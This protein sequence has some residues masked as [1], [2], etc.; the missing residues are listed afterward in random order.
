MI[1]AIHPIQQVSA[2]YIGNKTNNETLRLS[3]LPLDVTDEKLQELLRTYFLSNFTAPEFHNFTFSNE[4]FTLNPLFQFVKE[5][6]SAPETFHQNSI[7]MARHLYDVTQH[8]NIKAGELYIAFF[9]SIDV[10][11]ITADAVGIFKSENKENFLKLS[12]EFILQADTGINVKKLDKGCLILNTDED[13]G[14][15]VLLVDNLNK[16]DAQFWID[17]FLNVKAQSDAYHFTQTF[18]SMARNYVADE[19]DEEF[20]VSKADKIDLLNRSVEYFKSKEQFH[21]AEFETEVLGDVNVIESF[22]HY[23]KDFIQNSGFDVIDHFEISASAVKRQARIFKSVLKLDKNFHI[24]IHGNRELI[25]KGY[26]EVT[27]KHYYK[28]YF[29]NES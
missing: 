3:E 2:H 14:Y 11:N 15:K 26:D 7:N 25:E 8:P 19:I 10:G 20:S 1:A 12:P 21:Q 28:L 22:R 9:E 4:D 13:E 29:E 17:D 16:S 6:F 24:Y 27:G 18:M 5:I 23:S